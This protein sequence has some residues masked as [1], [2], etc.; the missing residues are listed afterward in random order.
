MKCVKRS[1][2]LFWESVENPGCDFGNPML[3][4][5]GVYFFC[6]EMSNTSPEGFRISRS[7][8]KQMKTSDVLR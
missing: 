2:K 4:L 6:L 5:G 7:V 3:G 8:L 1:N